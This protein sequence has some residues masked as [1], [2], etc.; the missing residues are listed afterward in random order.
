MLQKENIAGLCFYFQE[1]QT[2]NVSEELLKGMSNLSNS[3][4]KMICYSV[5]VSS[6]SKSFICYDECL[7]N[8]DV[9]LKS[10]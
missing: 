7:L 6:I 4:S 5:H 10:I 3:V 1:L 9:N 2:L 8:Y